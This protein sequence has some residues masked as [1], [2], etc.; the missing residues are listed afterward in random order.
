MALSR[1]KKKPAVP[2]GSRSTAPVGGAGAPQR[3]SGQ[4]VGKRKANELASSVDSSEPAN[5]RPAPSEGSA[6]L[7][8]SAPAV[9]G[10]QADLAAGN[11]VRPRV[12]R[13]TRLS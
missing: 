8:A 5:R 4:L 1:R 9:T 3:K 6:P 13:R 2:A 11:S 10:E 7:P 12:G